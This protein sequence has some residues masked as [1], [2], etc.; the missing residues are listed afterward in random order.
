MYHSTDY[1]G[2]PVGAKTRIVMSV[3]AGVFFGFLLFEV[4]V[5]LK[6]FTI[7]RG[8]YLMLGIANGILLGFIE[9]RTVIRELNEKTKARIWRPFVILALTLFLPY[10]VAIGVF[11]V[12]ENLPFGVYV[13]LPWLPAYNATSGWYYYQ[14]EKRDKV[15]ILTSVFGFTYWK[16]PLPDYGNMFANF[17]SDLAKRDYWWVTN[18]RGYVGYTKQLKSALEAKTNVDPETKETLM[19]IL[20]VMEKYRR[21]GFQLYAAV[22]ASMALL[23]LWILV[24]AST[25]TFGLQQVVNHKIV[26]GREISLVLGLVPAA[27]F[28]TFFLVAPRL[29]WKK[30]KKT[31]TSLL[32]TIDS[33][34]FYLLL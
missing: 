21:R 12:S 9:T 18:P 10:L 14:A 5:N 15:S 16:E 34:K 13:V 4:S 25:N 29:H 8:L 20:R 32:A 6:W 7:I 1:R 22:M 17:V 3:I 2:V 19:D 26:S 30:F 31:V 11:G 24:I 27:A 23:T 28:F 33:D